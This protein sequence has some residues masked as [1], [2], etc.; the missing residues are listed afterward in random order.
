[1]NYI[2]LNDKGKLNA[3]EQK[4]A[5]YFGEGNYVGFYKKHLLQNKVKITREDFVA[6]EIP[7]IFNVL[8]KLKIDYC[9]EDYPEQLRKYMY[10]RVWETKLGY[11]KDKVFNDY[12]VDPVFIKPKDRLKKFT[13]FV[14]NSR[15]DWM[16]TEGAAD[17][18]IIICTDP[19]KFVSEYRVPVINGVIRDYCHYFGNS[20]MV[21][22]NEVQ[23][24]VTDYTD[25]PGAYCLDVGI[26]DTGETALI[27][28]NDAFACGSYTMSPETYGKLLTTRWNELRLTGK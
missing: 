15:D 7:V 22:K 3:D 27:E 6:G 8:K 18:T 19:V 12:L 24:M 1:M 11:M 20:T 16:L 28:I 26:L 13:G 17:G 10:R 23:K 9:H 25:A 2:Q 21:D 4:L 5:E 14:L